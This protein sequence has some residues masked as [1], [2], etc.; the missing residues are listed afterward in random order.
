MPERKPKFLRRSEAGHNDS[1]KGER[2][3][4]GERVAIKVHVTPNGGRYVE[5]DDLFET[6][7]VKKILGLE[8]VDSHAG[9]DSLKQE[10]GE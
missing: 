9:G 6:P 4:P 1:G 5:P 10:T 2:V 3:Q 7:F 8:N